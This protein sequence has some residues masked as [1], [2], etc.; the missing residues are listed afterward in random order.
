MKEEEN[1]NNT[2]PVQR[3]KFHEF[4]DKNTYYDITGNMNTW[5]IHETYEGTGNKTI[6]EEILKEIKRSDK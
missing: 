1:K 2:I 6:R 5:R 4:E 3:T